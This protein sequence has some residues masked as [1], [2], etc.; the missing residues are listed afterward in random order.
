MSLILVADDDRDIRD[1]VAFKLSNAGH[2]VVAVEDGPS[3]LGAL[4][5][6]LVEVAILDVSM[7]GM[8]GF[9]VC[10]SMRSE[11]RTASIPVL[12]LT[13]KAQEAD[14]QTGFAYGADDY[15]VKPFSP[16]ELLSRV[17]AVLARSR[18]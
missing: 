13:A 17:E 12:L 18:R 3:A 9:D 8:S 16:R 6:R 7:P 4:A 14:V 2:E 5:D 15:I 1:L 11:A 10:R